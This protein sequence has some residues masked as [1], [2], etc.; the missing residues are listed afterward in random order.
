[1]PHTSHRDESCRTCILNVTY[2]HV[3]SVMPV[4]LPVCP[5]QLIKGGMGVGGFLLCHLLVRIHTHC[6]TF[7]FSLSLAFAHSLSFSIS[8]SLSLS[9]SLSHSLT[10]SLTH[11]HTH[12]LS[13]SLSSLSLS[14]SLLSLSHTHTHTYALTQVY[15]DRWEFWQTQALKVLD[16]GYVCARERERERQRKIQTEK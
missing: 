14:L 5:N 12:Y 6:F 11:T 16:Q 15:G 2:D 13:L 3:T 9:H 10:L 1:V 7:S 4:S 8:L